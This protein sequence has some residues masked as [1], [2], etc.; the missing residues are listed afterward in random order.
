MFFC[1]SFNLLNFSYLD[2]GFT[3]WF[4]HVLTKKTTSV[5]LSKR[6]GQDSKVTP[7]FVPHIY[8]VRLDIQHNSLFIVVPRLWTLVDRYIAS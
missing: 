6:H 8:Q 3:P 4:S 7:W 1:L 5:A 2:L